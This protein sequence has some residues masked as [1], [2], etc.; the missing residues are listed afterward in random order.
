MMDD[1]QFL[2]PTLN[3]FAQ[4]PWT[5]QDKNRLIELEDGRKRR[6]GHKAVISDIPKT[7][8]LDIQNLH[9]MSIEYKRKTTARLCC[10]CFEVATKL[11]SYDYK[12]VRLQEKYCDLHL[13]MFGPNPSPS[14]S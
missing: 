5:D 11:V 8:D 13:E 10:C 9:P 12:G 14:H 7:A 3:E 1:D 2:R 6:R 4:E